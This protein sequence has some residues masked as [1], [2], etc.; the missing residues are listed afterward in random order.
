MTEEQ[1]QVFDGWF[2]AS[3]YDFQKN[4]KVR[5]RGRRLV[6]V[7]DILAAWKAVK[8]ILPNYFAMDEDDIQ[9]YIAN[10]YKTQNSDEGE[11]KRDP[12]MK[13]IQDWLAANKETWKISPNGKR[14]TCW[15]FGMPMDRDIEELTLA[16]Q[17]TVDSERLPYREGEIS[18]AARQYLRW[19]EQSGMA[20]IYSTIKYDPKYE[21]G[22]NKW[23]HNIYEYMKP[24][25]DFI[26]FSTMM[27]HWAWQVKRKMMGR[28]V[29]YHIWVNF[30][31]AAGIGKT[32]FIKKLCAPMEDVTSTTTISKIFDDTREIKRLTENLVLI[33]DELA[34]NVESE[35]SGKLNADQKAILK[36]IITGEYL[37]ARVY[38][39]Q[40]Q[41]KR[42]ITFSCVSSAN[43]HLYDIIYDE[44]TMRRFF[45]FHCTAEKPKDFAS[46]NRTLDHADF[47][48]K[49]IDEDL[50]RGYF[51]PDCECWEAVAKIQAGYYPTK[52]SVYEWITE[53]N[54]RPGRIRADQT[55]KAYRQYC[56]NCGFKP[57]ALTGF[58]SDI[59]HAM[60][61]AT[62]GNTVM[63]D[64][65]VTDLCKNQKYS[66]D[67]DELT[68][69]E[70]SPIDFAESAK[71]HSLLTGEMP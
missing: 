71:H 64:L 11:A 12:P 25:E 58:I 30:Y 46:I 52:S 67:L 40:N 29:V 69:A 26:T 43:N 62:V 28:D 37:D 2:T 44:T 55:Y 39:T 53:T 19:L 47:F 41:A 32:T 49:G 10:K 7:K 6:N 63:L 51:N 57:K 8:G 56:Q 13:F 22:C 38:G 54:A 48:W 45:E 35:E 31:G 59:K 1:F 70:E 21:E 65:T 61:A 24:E 42:K 68:A 15:E 3:R 18:R 9:E 20:T 17:C 16:I 33:F 34:L 4:G 60:P 50:D 66:A 27:K 5:D 23:L 36:S 14:I